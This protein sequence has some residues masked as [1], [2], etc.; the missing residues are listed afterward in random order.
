LWVPVHPFQY[1][2]P[3]TDLEWNEM[4]AIFDFDQDLV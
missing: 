3:P 4:V 1:R 2:P